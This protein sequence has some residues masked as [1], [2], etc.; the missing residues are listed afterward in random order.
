MTPALNR[1]VDDPTLNFLMGRA[2]WQYLMNNN[3]DY[4]VEDVRRYW[5][6][7]TRQE[8][9]PQRLNALG[10]VY[11]TEGN[12]D[13]ASDAWIRALR[14]SEEEPVVK[15]VAVEKTGSHSS[16][17]ALTAYAGSAL[18]L[19]KKAENKPPE[20]RTQLLSEAVQRRK[21]VFRDD[22]VSFQPDALAKNWMWSEK[23][24][25]DWKTLL[26]TK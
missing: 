10:F 4:T 22:S 24:I 12:L 5:E 2:A 15:T 23:A 6:A 25:A 17:D 13:R 8:P 21:Q 14:L 1:K 9:T 16:K 11:Y 20:R 3:Q 18:V 7:S 19:M 26:T